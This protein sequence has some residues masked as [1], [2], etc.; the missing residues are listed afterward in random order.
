MQPAAM[1][2]LGKESLDRVG[3]SHHVQGREQLSA[4]GRWQADGML[5]QGMVWYGMVWYGMVGC[6]NAKGSDLIRY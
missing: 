5:D 2:A 3:A 6:V 1:E 4:D